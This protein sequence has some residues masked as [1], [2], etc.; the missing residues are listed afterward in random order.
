MAQHIAHGEEARLVVLDDTAVGR[1]VDLA[2]A[3]G[4]E[5]VHG[6]VGRGSGS[7]MDEDFHVG[8]GNVLYLSGLYLSLLHR[9]GDGVD[10]ASGGLAER[11]LGDDKRLVVEFVY[12]GTHLQHASTLS[13]VILAHIDGSTRREVGIDGERLAL[14]IVYGSIAKLIK[15]VWQHLAAQTYGNALCSLCQQQGELGGERNRLLVAAVIGE[16]PVG[17][18]GIKHHVECEFGQTRL[19]VS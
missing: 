14:E 7:Q 10:E 17:C 2:V 5:C 12:L 8:R 11:N 1:D 18:F 16:L 19:Y 3:E 9:L 4:I 15:V 6:L 13:V